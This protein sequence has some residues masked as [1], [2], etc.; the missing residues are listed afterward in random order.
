MNRGIIK[1]NKKI[2]FHK[3]GEFMNKVILGTFT[4]I[5]STAFLFGCGT[6]NDEVEPNNTEPPSEHQEE[7]S[8][9]DNHSK[10]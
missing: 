5:L 7:Q 6:P 1:N 8:Q 2:H 3:R 4:A 9:N 10:E